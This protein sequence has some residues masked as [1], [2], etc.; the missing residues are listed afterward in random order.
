MISGILSDEKIEAGKL[1]QLEVF[2]VEGAELKRVDAALAR[3][4]GLERVRELPDFFH[5]DPRPVR[6][7]EDIIVQHVGSGML[8]RLSSMAKVS[9]YI[10][11]V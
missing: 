8:Y 2:R 1:G 4:P 5:G 9:Q 11:G 3:A 6:E 7:D 10:S